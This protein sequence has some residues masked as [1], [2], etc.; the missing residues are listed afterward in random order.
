M[1]T[2]VGRREGPVAEINV[3]P[4]ADVIIVLL[5]IFMVAVPLI[6]A[7]RSLV[8]PRAFNSGKQK[9]EIVVSMRPDG[10]IRVGRSVLSEPELLVRLQAELRDL[11]DAERL[12]YLRAD[13]GLPYER[14][15]SVLELCRQSGAE[16]VALMTAPRGP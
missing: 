9:E 10:S 5:I 7:D 12:V 14:V 6:T 16:T 13:E 8:L 1:A 15:A 3:T 2:S 4:M 11:A